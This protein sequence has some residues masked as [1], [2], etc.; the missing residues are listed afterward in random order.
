MRKF[1]NQKNSPTLTIRSSLYSK[2][3]FFS[4]RSTF[5]SPAIHSK[6]FSLPE[7]VTVLT[8]LSIV[9]TLSLTG[10]GGNGGI[11]SWATRSKIDETKALLNSAAADC[12]QKSRLQ[13]S[14][15]KNI[16]DE[17]ILSDSKLNKTGYKIDSTSNKCSYLQLLPTDEDD[18]LRYPIGFSVSDGKLSKFANPTST[19][20]GS[21]SSCQSWAGVNCKQDESLKELIAWKNKIEEEKIKCENTY[22]N[23]IRTKT[24]PY[25]SNRWNT[26][27]NSGCPSRPPNGGSTSYKTLDTCTYRGCNREVYG[28][29]GEFAGF[30]KEEYDKALEAKYG[31]LCTAWVTK[32]ETDKYTN[33]PL[34]QPQKKTECGDSREF[35]FYKGVNYNS[36]NDLKKAKCGISL[37]NKVAESKA[38][39]FDG[40]YT[41]LIGGPGM[42]AESVWLCKGEK[43]DSDGYKESSCKATPTPTPPPTPTPEE[44]V[45]KN[46]TGCFYFPASSHCD[47]K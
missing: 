2:L 36:L 3:L 10:I 29:D 41:P 13:N 43:L 25:L 8:I 22:N 32:K 15:T 11:L 40:K 24:L 21:I 19:D 35:W 28:L 6:G 7:L 34:E 14:A 23:Y 38:G 31:R 16:I 18:D 37:N 12:L 33:D 9:T 4:C 45:P 44:C 39:N 42:C 17:E 26:N 30:T 27:A 1:F 46:A 47:C 5:N 20:E